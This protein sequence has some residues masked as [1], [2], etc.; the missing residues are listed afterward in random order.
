MVLQWGSTC[1]QMVFEPGRADDGSV[2]LY[3]FSIE[4]ASVSAP[5]KYKIQICKK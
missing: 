2:S 5:V 1:S 3:K 4:E